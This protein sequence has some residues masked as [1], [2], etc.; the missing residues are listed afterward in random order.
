MLLGLEIFGAVVLL[1]GTILLVVF[2]IVGRGLRARAERDRAELEREGI[3]LDGGM[4]NAVVRY[5]GYSEPGLYATLSVHTAAKRL[6]LTRETLAILGSRPKRIPRAELH[7]YSVTTKDGKLV[8]CSDNPVGA[9][10]HVEMRIAV[11]DPAAWT[12]A[13]LEA[14]ASSA[15]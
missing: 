1:V 3:V 8:V 7:R 11:D 12:R 6:V 13:L 5:E 14:G 4:R 2:S 9:S 10:G 15:G